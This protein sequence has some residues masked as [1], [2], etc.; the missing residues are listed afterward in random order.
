MYQIHIIE[1]IKVER[2]LFCQAVSQGVHGQWKWTFLLC[3]FFWKSWWTKWVIKN[4]SIEGK[5]AHGNGGIWVISYINKA[6]GIRS[7]P[8][9]LC[10]LHL[11]YK[12]LWRSVSVSLCWNV[13][14]T[15]NS[16]GKYILGLFQVYTYRKWMCF[17]LKA[18]ITN[19]QWV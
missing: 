15:K 13:Q 2:K 12:M 14:I 1:Q 17:S 18:P 16:V 6:S 4:C 9:W 10:A 11:E 5:E 7:S 19:V 8:L 3:L